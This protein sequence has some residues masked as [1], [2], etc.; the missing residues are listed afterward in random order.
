VV[1]KTRKKCDHKNVGVLVYR[2]GRKLLLL[3]RIRHPY[4]WSPPAMHADND[5]ENLKAAARRAVLEKTGL[6]AQKFVL[7]LKR[8][9]ENQCMRRG[10]RWHNLQVFKAVAWSG[11]LKRSQTET[12]NAL[13]VSDSKLRALACL[14]ETYIKGKISAKRWQKNPGLEVV[15][16]K[17]FKNLGII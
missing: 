6:D 11:K 3:E 13:W 10:G 16:H 7:L 2:K 12:K 17:I 15:W 4:G 9:C 1:K 8:A 5:G 14:T